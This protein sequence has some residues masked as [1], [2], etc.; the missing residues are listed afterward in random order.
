MLLPLYGR[1]NVFS[2]YF[3]CGVSDLDSIIS[4]EYFLGDLL[5]V[6]IGTISALNVRE[7]ESVS[8]LQ[9]LGMNPG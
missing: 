6:N 3:E 7:Y 9:N 5:V 1:K 4:D 8:F 2:N